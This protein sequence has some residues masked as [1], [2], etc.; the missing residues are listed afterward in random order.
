MS[1]GGPDSPHKLFEEVKR[2]IRRALE[3]QQYS[4]YES[5]CRSLAAAV[6]GMN[7]IIAAPPPAAEEAEG[8][9]AECMQSYAT[10]YRRLAEGNRKLGR[11]IALPP[12]IVARSEKE[13]AKSKGPSRLSYKQ[14]DK[15]PIT[16]EPANDTPQRMKL[17]W[18]SAKQGHKLGEHQQRP[19]ASQES[20]LSHQ[21]RDKEDA[22]AGHRCADDSVHV[23]RATNDKDPIE[24][25]SHSRAERGERK[26][27]CKAAELAISFH[28]DN[29]VSRT[30]QTHVPATDIDYNDATG[31]IAGVHSESEEEGLHILTGGNEHTNKVLP[32]QGPNSKDAHARGLEAES[33]LF[34]LLPALSVPPQ[35]EE[36]VKGLPRPLLTSRRDLPIIA[37]KEYSG[38]SESALLTAI[39]GLLKKIPEFIYSRLH[40]R[41]FNVKENLTAKQSLVLFGNS[42]FPQDILVDVRN[43]VSCA[44]QM[45]KHVLASAAMHTT[46][47]IYG[48]K[49]S[50]KTVLLRSISDRCGF[51]AIFFNGRTAS[52]D[53]NFFSSYKELFDAY[54]RLA[55]ACRPSLFILDELNVLMAEQDFLPLWPELLEHAIEVIGQ[56]GPN[57]RVV[58]I[59]SSCHPQSFDRALVNRMG[60]LIEF[61]L[62]TSAERRDMVHR[63]VSDSAD[64]DSIV[65]QTDR[66]SLG[67]LLRLLNQASVVQ[68]KNKKPTVTVASVVEAKR[69]IGPTADNEY[70]T[71]LERWKTFIGAR[72]KPEPRVSSRITTK[73]RQPDVVV[74]SARSST[75]GFSK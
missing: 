50:G 10:I 34:S 56:F 30:E 14:Q 6:E 67:D 4:Q 49:N 61:G 46:F 19:V 13:G 64:V 59:V 48:P 29:G 54:L 51:P 31:N 57:E 37:R 52:A 1:S 40:D 25:A 22:R 7:T 11:K 26:V 39:D 71:S 33:Q 24:G 73:S 23:E 15:M 45:L 35:D 72:K 20:S 65:Q 43:Y 55:C 41:G 27:S 8:V 60:V 32:V 47:M 63:V 16:E 21:L 2:N 53:R 68:V 17:D 62:S 28:K 18:N 38:V 3:Y 5:Y 12:N 44:E 74:L 70:V 42:S 75:T 36:V 66:Y 9:Y 69:Y 58:L